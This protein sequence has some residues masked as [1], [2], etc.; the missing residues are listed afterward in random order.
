MDEKP[1]YW[2]EY[3]EA[4]CKECGE[5]TDGSEPLPWDVTWKILH[6]TRAQQRR[7]EIWAI[8]EHHRRVNAREQIMEE[9]HARFGI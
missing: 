1:Y 8:E 4:L 3:I 5:Y 9:L 2:Q 6:A 7:A